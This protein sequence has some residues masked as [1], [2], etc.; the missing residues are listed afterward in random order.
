M[1]ETMTILMIVAIVVIVIIFLMIVALAM[2]VSRSNQGKPAGQQQSQQQIIQQIQRPAMR[3][4]AP[5]Q[6][7]HMPQQPYS[8]QSDYQH[9]YDQYGRQQ[10]SQDLRRKHDRPKKHEEKHIDCDKCGKKH[11]KHKGCGHHGPPCPDSCAPKGHHHPFP[12]PRPVAPELDCF[13]RDEVTGFNES[14]CGYQA[15][16]GNWFI[17]WQQSEDPYHPTS[18]YKVYSKKGMHTDVGPANNDFV[19]TRPVGNGLAFY[20]DASAGFVPGECRSFAV[21]QTSSCG[22][23]LPSASFSTNCQI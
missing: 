11:D 23:S 17:G 9:Q 12:C 20:F 13:E 3:Q 18:V 1:A 6:T 22:E 10:H 15:A 14:N 2:S 5:K 8:S 4:V 16:T 7:Q 19:Y 21:T